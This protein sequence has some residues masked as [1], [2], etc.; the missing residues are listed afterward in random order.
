MSD[1]HLDLLSGMQ[2]AGLGYAEIWLG[3]VAMGGT[4]DEMEVEAYL[5]GL[6][7]PPEHQH[8]LLAQAINEHFIER[9]QDHPVAYWDEK[10]VS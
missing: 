3:Q 5:V 7:E 1:P 8:N 9:G 6:L 2:A 10:P 4:A